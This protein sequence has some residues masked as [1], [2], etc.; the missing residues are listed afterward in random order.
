M[1][2]DNIGGETEKWALDLLKPW[3]GA[4][5]VTLVTPFLH[6]TDQLGLADGMMQSGVTIGCKVLKV[7]TSCP[8][9]G[10]KHLEI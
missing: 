10:E 9:A 7:D 8:C 4:K 3:N 6:N 5:Y 1:I 2:L